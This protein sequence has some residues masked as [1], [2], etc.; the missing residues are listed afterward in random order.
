MPNV[1]SVPASADLSAI[2]YYFVSINSSG[3]IAATGDGE[4]PDG[5]LQNKPA[6]A[7]RACA[8]QT[9]G[10]SFVSCGAAVTAGDELCSDSSGQAINGS[11]GDVLGA[12]ALEDGSAADSIIRCLISKRGT[13]P[14]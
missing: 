13:T 2:Q 6:A 7:N 1:I 10:E 8:V 9:D 3:L 14:S 4:R 11:S 12:I 5:I